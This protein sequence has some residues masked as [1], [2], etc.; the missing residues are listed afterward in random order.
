MILKLLISPSV[1]LFIATFIEPTFITQPVL[2]IDVIDKNNP[3]LI[4]KK[5][6]GRG[7][8]V[9]RQSDKFLSDQEE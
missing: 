8:Q 4:L 6:E 9:T 3:F 1:T 2:C 5:T 7:G